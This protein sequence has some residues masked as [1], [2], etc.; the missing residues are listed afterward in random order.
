MKNF[1]QA[2]RIRG[3]A[4]DDPMGR[5]F[6]T[7]AAELDELP[8]HLQPEADL[9]QGIADRL[10][11][12]APR[13]YRGSARFLRPAASAQAW[14]QA[15]AAG[16][17]LVAG[18]LLTW[19]AMGGAVEGPADRPDDAVGDIRLAGAATGH[20]DAEAQFLRA[21]EE[22]WLVVFSRR[23]QLSPEAWR[24]VEQNLQ[25]LDG[26]VEDLRAALAEDPGNPDLE[27]RILRTQRRSLDLLRDV[28]DG[29]SDSV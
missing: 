1:D 5:D 13:R 7:L 26:A 24:M 11:P 20:G 8:A 16:L 19:L 10:Q 28:A 4:S 2:D 14:R 25:I 22:M 29:M 12:R 6:T 9:W 23:D 18:A 21:K 17:G 27:R 15:L 3:P